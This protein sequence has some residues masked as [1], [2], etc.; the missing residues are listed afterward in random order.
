VGSNPTRHPNSTILSYLLGAELHLKT[1][2]R[3]THVKLYEA[4]C[5]F[6]A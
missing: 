2:R 5:N 3:G 6:S 1:A 4:A